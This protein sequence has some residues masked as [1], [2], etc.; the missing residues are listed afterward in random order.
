MNRRY[1]C[2]VLIVSAALF[3]RTNSERSHS[4]SAVS[5]MSIAQ[6]K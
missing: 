6:G 2:I 1:F 3:L 5:A 4:V